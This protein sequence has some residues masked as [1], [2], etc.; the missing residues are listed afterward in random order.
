MSI[1]LKT[2]GIT[3][4]TAYTVSKEQK[5]TQVVNHALDGTTHVQII[6][7]PHVSYKIKALINDELDRN[8]LDDAWQDGTLISSAVTTGGSTTTT[9]LGVITNITWQGPL[10]GNKYLAEIDTVA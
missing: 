4:S 6:G 9:T 10:P 7:Q 1:A 8:V 5:P 3:V 2:G